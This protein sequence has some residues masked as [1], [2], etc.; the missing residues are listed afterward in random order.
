SPEERAQAVVPS[1]ALRQAAA[2]VRGGERSALELAQAIRRQLETAPLAQ[3]QYTDIVDADTL[4]PVETLV[5]DGSSGG[6][7]LAAVAVYFGAT[8]LIDNTTLVVGE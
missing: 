6:R 4:Q 8:R 3:V 1:Q 5:Q 2:A 7:Y